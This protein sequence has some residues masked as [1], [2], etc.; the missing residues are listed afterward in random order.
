MLIRLE[1]KGVNLFETDSGGLDKDIDIGRS[2][3]CAWRVPAEDKD[4]S[5]HH[6]RISHKG[7]SVFI[8]DLDSSNGTYYRGKKIKKLKLKP[9]MRVSVGSCIVATEAGGAEGPVEVIPEIVMLSGKSRGV[10]K[11]IRPGT[12]TVGSD[13]SS[14]L[15]LL[16]MLVSRH[17]AE[18]VMKEDKSCWIKDLGSKNGTSV[19]D[20]PLRSGQERL[21][22]EGDKVAF[23]HFEARFYD[24]T[25]K[26]SNKK[27]WLR[28]GIVVATVL[29]VTALY[30]GYQRLKPASET[31][32]D[33]ARAAS[34]DEDFDQARKFMDKAAQARGAANRELEISD[35]SRLVTL[36]EGTL[37]TWHSAQAGLTDGDWV[38]ASRDLGSLSTL[39]QDAW[40]WSPDA[41][42][43]KNEALRA[44]T[45]LDTLLRADGALRG[46]EAGG[47]SLQAELESVKSVLASNAGDIPEYLGK[48]RTELIDIQS[49][50]ELFLSESHDLEAALDSLSAWPPPLV[51]TIHVLEE[52]YKNSRG[53][54]KR[55]SEL[56]L[57]PVKALAG[58]YD[59]LAHALDLAHD[60]KF[61]DALQVT[62]DLP[63]TSACALD[64]RVSACRTAIENNQEKL[65]IQI[66]QLM[67]LFREV[68]KLVANPDE[69]TPPQMLAWKN[70]DALS[71][72]LGCDSLSYPMPR[73]S[74]KEA[75]GEY[76]RYLG[77][78]EFYEYMVAMSLRQPW[79][80]KLDAPFPTILFQTQSI[81]EAVESIQAFFANEDW[82]VQ[83]TPV[84]STYG[85]TRLDN[86]PGTGTAPASSGAPAPAKK[87][88]S[89]LL[90]GKLQE[91][92][93]H[94]KD[95][96][97]ARDD[98]VQRMLRVATELEDRPAMMA[99][100]IAYRLA[101]NPAT[102]NVKDEPLEAYLVRHMQ[103]TRTRLRDL[104]QAYDLAG[105]AKQIELRDEILKVG[106][107]GDPIVKRMWSS[108]TA[109]QQ[110]NQ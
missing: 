78:E 69:K 100:G 61:S 19:N 84:N 104:S 36:W 62:L 1:H 80:E 71:K 98:L 38:R 35:L 54:L 32:L 45:L 28:V 106:L 21:L 74:R 103:D 52:T 58:S 16:D 44:K 24:G 33:R 17:H 89:W 47:S 10:R 43:V 92:V 88:T 73:R 12:F 101:E 108:S 30:G 37:T 85:V 53:L 99:A 72:M 23:A 40:T 60:M 46:D 56:M 79:K 26:R 76:D 109:S 3:N 7:G 31:Y 65:N 86:A 8:E 25:T 41:A 96:L 63:S 110:P 11:E 68:D 70:K 2:S 57:D 29:V 91:R 105:P 75:S 18:I 102:L 48:A 39:K 49:K 34:A 4:V 27:V 66:N 64:T 81:I 9:G 87:E 93:N 83:L 67:Y 50:L 22:K 13:P 94:L 5:S 20:T 42:D 59:R 15:I 55:R 77:I 51:N 107:P 90:A 14:S 95:I 97:A 82:A 6:A